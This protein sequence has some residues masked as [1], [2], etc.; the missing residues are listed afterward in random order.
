[1]LH[2]TQPILTT[3][4]RRHITTWLPQVDFKTLMIITFTIFFWASAFAGIRAGLD[5][6]T[7][8]QLALLRYLV[9]SAVLAGY[10][11]AVRLPLPRLRDWPGIALVGFL[12]FSLYNIALNIGQQTVSAGVA[13]FIISAE[14]GL[15]AILAMIF[16]GERLKAVGWLGIAICFVGVCIIAIGTSDSW[17]ISAGALWVFVATISISLYTV[18]QKPYLS[19][20]TA[21]QFTAYAIWAGTFF[22]LMFAPGLPQA[23]ATAPMEATVAVI[24]MG[25]FPGAVAYVGWSY[26]LAHIPASRAGSLLTLIPAVALFVAWVWLGEIPPL[27]GLVGG[28]V[29]VTGVILVNTIGRTKD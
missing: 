4:L 21:L 14:V 2:R 25:I 27:I 12:G 23:I 8:G 5:G 28:V 20:Y 19:R 26:V 24:Y 1:M 10:A 11:I 9:A 15:I 17:T 3:T 22:M 16:F 7:P 18:M 29:V 13:S 6:Y